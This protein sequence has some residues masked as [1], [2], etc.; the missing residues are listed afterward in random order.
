[1]N[2]YTPERYSDHKALFVSFLFA[3]SLH[4]ALFIL[5]KRVPVFGTVKKVN[6]PRLKVHLRARVPVKTVY[7]VR[8]SKPSRFFPEVPPPEKTVPKSPKKVVLK[9]PKKIVKSKAIHSPPKKAIRQVKKKIVLPHKELL[10][11]PKESN[12][13]PEDTSQESLPLPSSPSKQE[14]PETKQAATPPP[15]PVK[16]E[17][18]Y[19][20]YGKS[21]ALSYPTL[22]RRR[23]YEGRVVLK[24]LVSKGGRVLKVTLAKSSGHSILDKAAMKAVK[25]WIFKPG[26]LNG[27][28]VEMWVKVPVVYELR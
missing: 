14:I 15:T 28:T 16:R 11:P 21:P 19:P 23:G 8:Q 13:D 9:K 22:A 12:P 1:M 17:L 3:V 26:K 7:D 4:A 6:P 20:D 5:V 10:L 25:E 24:V 27:N 18:A 2:E